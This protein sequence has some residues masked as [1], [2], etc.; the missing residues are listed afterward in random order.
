[1]A[2][3][4]SGRVAIVGAYLEG[5]PEDKGAAYVFVREGPSWEATAR[6]TGSR[7]VFDLSDENNPCI[8]KFGQSVAISGDANTVLVGAPGC[9]AALEEA[10][11]FQNEEDIWKEKAILT[12]SGGPAANSFGISVALAR[13]GDTALVGGAGSA[14]VFHQ[15]QG[16]RDWR[17][18]AELG[19]DIFEKEWFGFSVDIDDAGST[20]LIGD[21]GL[22]T[23]YGFTRQDTAGKI[24]WR[25]HLVVSS[26]ELEA[27]VGALGAHVA[28]SG[29]AETLLA[30]Y[31]VYGPSS[32]PD[33]RSGACT[34]VHVLQRQ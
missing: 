16:N 26:V 27:A 30:S 20:A 17:E 13:N 2:L 31:S 28:I 8:S 24:E 15:D 12:A 14:Y 11:L 10:Y 21:W 1:M 7:T 32:C 6:L 3:S 33:G 23:V 19:A 22:G 18:E 4:D 25:P 29:N 9:P 34:V 5:I